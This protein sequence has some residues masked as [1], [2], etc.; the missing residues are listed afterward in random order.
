MSNP[1]HRIVAGG[2]AG[3]CPTG[4]ME[5]EPASTGRSTEKQVSTQY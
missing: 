5:T 1:F 3:K 4:N 2:E